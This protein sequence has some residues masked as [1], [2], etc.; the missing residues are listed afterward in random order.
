M[1]SGTKRKAP[2][3][4]KGLQLQNRFTTL[5]VEEEPDMV[6]SRSC[7]PPDPKSYKTPRRKQ[8]VTVV[9]HS[10]L[11]WTE[12]PVCPPD[13][14]SR[15]ICCLLET[16]IQGVVEGLRG[17]SNPFT[18]THCFFCVSTKSQTLLS[19]IQGTGQEPTGT[20]LNTGGS[21]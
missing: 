4:P 20:N 13:Q 15:G 1:P 6:S 8:Q 17:L 21:I 18:I 5:K 16:W 14:S 19:G 10:L 2:A 3:P 11:L 12:A 9:G 7:G